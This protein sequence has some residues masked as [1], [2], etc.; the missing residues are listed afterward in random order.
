MTTKA[1]SQSV[2][3]SAAFILSRM[4]LYAVLWFGFWAVIDYLRAPEGFHLKVSMSYLGFYLFAG[5]LCALAHWQVG[6]DKKRR[7]E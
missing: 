1:L 2:I 4:L 6:G 3:S 5:W 7:S